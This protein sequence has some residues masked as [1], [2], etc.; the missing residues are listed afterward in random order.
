MQY[1][2]P[3]VK[4]EGPMTKIYSICWETGL[5]LLTNLNPAYTDQ[6]VLKHRSLSIDFIDC[7]KRLNNL[8]IV[9]GTLPAHNRSY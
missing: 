7:S 9:R 8:Q 6:I 3:S 4:T 2:K 1:K 5:A